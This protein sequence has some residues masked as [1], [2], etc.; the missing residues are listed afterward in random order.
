[1]T[2]YLK[3]W[4]KLKLKYNSNKIFS[5]F[6]NPKITYQHKI[7]IICG[8]IKTKEDHGYTVDLGIDDL[9]G[10]L[11]TNDTT[12]NFSIGQCSLFKIESKKSKRAISLE[13]CDSSQSSFYDL[14]TKF[15]FDTYLPGARLINCTVEKVSK[16]GLQLNISNQLHAYVHINHVPAAKRAYLAKSKKSVQDFDT[17]SAKFYSNG[18]KLTGTIIFINPYSR[19]IYM[20]LLPHLND[21]TKPAKITKLF[22]EDRTENGPGLKLGQVIDEA[23]VSM[24]TQKEV[25]VKFKI[26]EDKKQITGFVPK[27]QLFESDK[28]EGGDDDEE[29][30]DEDEEKV[31]GEKLKK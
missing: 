13:L 12:L 16:G 1:M 17:S 2:Q 5:Q 18:D 7:K 14:K 11:R 4:I 3:K 28:T 29:D 22:L 19:V 20:S 10:F 8:A 15:Q 27:K 30:D 6:K 31:N 26:G 25:Y 9:S 21:S 24:V 23:Q